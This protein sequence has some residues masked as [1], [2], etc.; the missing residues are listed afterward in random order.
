LLKQTIESR[1][2]LSVPHR[3]GATNIRICAPPFRNAPFTS[4]GPSLR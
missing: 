3:T 2:P 1:E 4:C